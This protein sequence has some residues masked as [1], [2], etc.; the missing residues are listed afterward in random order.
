MAGLLP[1]IVKFGVTVSALGQALSC[2]SWNFLQRVKR[3]LKTSTYH[4]HFLEDNISDVAVPELVVW[5][6]S[7]VMT[8]CGIKW[9]GLCASLNYVMLFGLLDRGA[10]A[11]HDRIRKDRQEPSSP[12]IESTIF[13]RS[14]LKQFFFEFVTNMHWIGMISKAWQM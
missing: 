12:Y 8:I 4:E 1:T 10:N 6:T 3:T 5:I 7:H 9:L 13:F 11:G 2:S 14:F